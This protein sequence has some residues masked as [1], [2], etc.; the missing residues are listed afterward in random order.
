MMSDT[1]TVAM[2]ARRILGEEND[3]VPIPYLLF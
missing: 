2:L 3:K 1:V